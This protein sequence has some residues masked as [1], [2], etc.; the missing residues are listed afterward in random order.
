MKDVSMLELYKLILGF[1]PV[2]LGLSSARINPDWFVNFV[3]FFG[4]LC[5]VVF[6]VNS[7]SFTDAG[8]RKFLFYFCDI[9]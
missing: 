7:D 8:I 1:T 5:S 9:L 3:I 6:G 4:S 2:V